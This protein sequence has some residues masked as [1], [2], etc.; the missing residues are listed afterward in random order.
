MMSLILM[1]FL[2]LLGTNRATAETELV[3]DQVYKIVPSKRQQATGWI[4]GFMYY[5]GKED[6]PGIANVYL[7]GHRYYLELLGEFPLGRPDRGWDASEYVKKALKSIPES[8]DFSLVLHVSGGV[9]STTDSISKFLSE[10]CGFSQDRCKITTYVGV[11]GFCGSSCVKVF[12]M[13]TERIAA[14]SAAFFMHSSTD[15][16]SGERQPERFPKLLR[17]LST[18]TRII[19]PKTILSEDWID[20]QVREGVFT[21]AHGREYSSSALIAQNSGMLTALQTDQAFN[22]VL[23]NLGLAEMSSLQKFEF[24]EKAV[25]F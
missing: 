2:S 13:G 10:K 16:F 6:N 5:K 25:T 23:I 21:T 22:Q 14:E 17:E 1:A 15:T 20:Q 9:S 8:T 19:S 7:V 18:Y 24:F 11:D 4:S 3:I 12:L